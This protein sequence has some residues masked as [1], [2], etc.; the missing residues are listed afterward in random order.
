M[1][2]VFI[3]NVIIDI[4]KSHLWRIR[5][6]TVLGSIMAPWRCPCS[7]LRTCPYVTYGQRDFTDGI[8]LTMG[9]LS[10]IIWVCP[11]QLHWS[12]KGIELGAAGFEEGRRRLQVMN[13]AWNWEWLSAYSQWQGGEPVLQLPKELNSVKKP[14][15]CG[16]RYSPTSSRKECSL[17]IHRFWSS[18][19]SQ[20][21][22]PPE[23]E[24]NKSMLFLSH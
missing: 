4:K 19:T 15:W 18:E 21:I 6:Q 1:P 7:D 11:I 23:L 12:V 10:W 2:S 22:W 5:G 8:K 14:E 13:M 24:D 17:S 3:F 20:D 9:K 16:S